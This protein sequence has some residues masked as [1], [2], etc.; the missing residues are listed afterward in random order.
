MNCPLEEQAE[1]IGRWL[2]QTC[3]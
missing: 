3:D 2:M 1:P